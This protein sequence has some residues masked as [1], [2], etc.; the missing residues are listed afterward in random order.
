[1]KRAAIISRQICNVR[2]IEPR[3]EDALDHSSL[4]RSFLSRSFFDLLYLSI[5]FVETFLR[6]KRRSFQSFTSNCLSK[7]NYMLLTHRFKKFFV[8]YYLLKNVKWSCSW[9]YSIFRHSSSFS[10]SID[11]R[12][13]MPSPLG[14]FDLLYLLVSRD[15]VHREQSSSHWR[16]WLHFKVPQ[17]ATRPPRRASQPVQHSSPFF[18]FSFRFFVYAA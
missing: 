16:D 7:K 6:N 4:R 15:K 8:N 14:I 17:E 12:K 5:F 13:S 11:F 18:V 3:A 1:M 10:K 9:W 2:E